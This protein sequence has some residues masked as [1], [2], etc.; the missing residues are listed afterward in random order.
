M[1][2]RRVCEDPAAGIAARFRF[3]KIAGI[4]CKPERIIELRFEEGVV[5]SFDCEKLRGLIPGIETVLD[6]SL[7]FTA[8]RNEKYGIAWND[9]LDLSADYLW[10]VGTTIST[11]FTGLLSMKEA[12]DRWG[13][14]E[15]TLRK[16][17]AAGRFEIGIDAQK[18]GKQWVLTKGS[19]E[20]EYGPELSEIRENMVYPA[21]VMRRLKNLHNSK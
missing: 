7:A 18:Y 6:D 19:V 11:A 16:A 5:K 17:I 14:N 4:Q 2:D 15:S 13:I 1:A 3:H 20:R 10:D 21:H 9:D 12:T 8:V